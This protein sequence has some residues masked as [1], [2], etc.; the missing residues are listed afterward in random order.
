MRHEVLLRVFVCSCDIGGL[1]CSGLRQR[2]G[3]LLFA[4]FL[5]SKLAANWFLARQSD[6]LNGP[7]GGQSDPFLNEL[8]VLL[9]LLRRF[10]RI[11]N[12]DVLLRKC[13]LIENAWPPNPPL[14]LLYVEL[15]VLLQFAHWRLLHAGSAVLVVGQDAV[16]V[17]LRWT[18]VS[19]SDVIMI[20]GKRGTQSVHFVLSVDQLVHRENPRSL[21]EFHGSYR[22]LVKVSRALAN[23]IC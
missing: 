22:I 6:R 20:F 4:E 3:T 16:R 10:V 12:V 23:G 15:I 21:I 11:D 14:Q 9:L 1:V 5:Q 19:W 8:L 7:C 2:S 17:Q 13:L 18:V